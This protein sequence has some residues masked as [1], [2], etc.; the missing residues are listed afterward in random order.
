MAEPEQLCLDI[1]NIAAFVVSSQSAVVSSLNVKWS[2]KGTVVIQWK[3]HGQ[4]KFFEQMLARVD[5]SNRH[6]AAVQTAKEGNGGYHREVSDYI[7]ITIDPCPPLRVP[8]VGT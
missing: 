6:G 8:R 4:L 3:R 2:K 7:R 5:R 1:S